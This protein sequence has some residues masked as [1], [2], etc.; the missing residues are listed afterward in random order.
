MTLQDL[1]NTP[2]SGVREYPNIGYPFR[3]K[4]LA[5]NK[6]VNEYDVPFEA[7][8]FTNRTNNRFWIEILNVGG[9]GRSLIYYVTTTSQKKADLWVAAVKAGF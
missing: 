4:V 1:Y 2:W 5:E 7:K 3:A 9:G 8:V 6:F